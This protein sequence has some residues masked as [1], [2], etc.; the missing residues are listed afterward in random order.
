MTDILVRRTHS[1]Q[2]RVRNYAV[3]VDGRVTAN[4]GNGGAV[5]VPVAA[6]RHTVQLRIDWC[7]SNPVDISVDAHA[8]VVLEC[9]PNATPWFALFYVTIWYRKYLWLRVADRPPISQP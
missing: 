3:I 2:D 6:G 8:P 1:W 9:G 7:R 5:R 4:I